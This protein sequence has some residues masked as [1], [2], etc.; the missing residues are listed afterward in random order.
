MAL[1]WKNTVICLL[2]V[3]LKRSEQEHLKLCVEDNTTKCDCSFPSPHYTGLKIYWTTTCSWPASWKCPEFVSRFSMTALYKEASKETHNTGSY[4]IQSVRNF[5]GCV[6]WW[7]EFLLQWR[8]L[9]V[10]KHTRESVQVLYNE[11]GLQ[12][13]S[14][15]QTERDIWK[16]GWIRGAPRLKAQTKIG[17][18][19]SNMSLTC[20]YIIIRSVT[21]PFAM[22]QYFLLH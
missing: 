11:G 1:H 5:T 9:L 21:K 22:M 20:W 15:K 14:P 7:A 8:F 10:F 13:I 2:C 3:Q 17:P 4:F 16:Y 12:Q 19:G 18:G 6:D